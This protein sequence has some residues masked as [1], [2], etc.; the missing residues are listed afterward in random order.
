M[1]TGTNV[2]EIIE[3]LPNGD[4]VRLI[5]NGW[6]PRNKKIEIIQPK[7]DKITL[8]DGIENIEMIGELIA[9]FLEKE[10]EGEYDE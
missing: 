2:N 6:H 8:I 3:S 4:I 1:T 5:G 10:E 9:R 7:I